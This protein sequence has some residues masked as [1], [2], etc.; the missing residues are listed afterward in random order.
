[1]EKSVGLRRGFTVLRWIAGLNY[2]S[3]ALIAS[4]HIFPM[5]EGTTPDGI[6]FFTALHASKFMLPLLG[7]CFLTGGLLLLP[8][9]TAP[10]GLILLAPPIVVIPLY[11][12][13]LERQPFTSGPFVVTIEILLAW[14]YWDRFQ[15]LWQGKKS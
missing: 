7:L 2:V 15:P 9:R 6:A 1:M 10:L 12:W 11:N 4:F 5:P 13:L 14:Y 8:D 3:V